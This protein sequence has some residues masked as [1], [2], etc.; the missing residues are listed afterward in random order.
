MRILIVDDDEIARGLLRNTLKHAGYK[1]TTARDGREALEILR[2]QPHSMVISDW[3]MPEADGTQLCRAIRAE[4]FSTYTYVI[5]LTSRDQAED[6]VEGLTAG[7][8]DFITKPFQPAELCLRVR[9]GERVL[10]LE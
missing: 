4:A 1:V 7:A 6:I 3:V 9:A 5:L 10:S 2:R 8:D